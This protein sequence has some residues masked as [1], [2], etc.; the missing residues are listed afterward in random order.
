METEEDYK[1]QLYAMREDDLR[2]H[3]KHETG[4]LPGNKDRPAMIAEFL[5]KFRAAGD[6]V[7]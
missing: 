2:Y 3:Y 6:D 1:L 5:L 4:E 7:E